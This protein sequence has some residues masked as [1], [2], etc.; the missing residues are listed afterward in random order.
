M[1]APKRKEVT[2]SLG[3]VTGYIT[4]DDFGKKSVSSF[5]GKPLG[6]SDGKGTYD[7]LGKT[8]SRSDN[9]GMLLDDDDEDDDD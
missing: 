9:P 5:L 8:V 6:H 7:F 4:E 3:R 1:S 2:D